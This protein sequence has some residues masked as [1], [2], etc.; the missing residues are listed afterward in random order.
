MAT[1]EEGKA[2]K[3]VNGTALVSLDFISNEV[4][5]WVCVRD[6]IGIKR[7]HLSGTMVKQSLWLA[8][9]AYAYVMFIL[10]GVYPL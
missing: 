5:F 2:G 8:P 3:G 10:A 9:E 6:V 7:Y 1:E 4:T